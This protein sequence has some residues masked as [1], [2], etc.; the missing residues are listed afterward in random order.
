MLFGVRQADGPTGH[1]HVGGDLSGFAGDAHHGL[2]AGLAFD[3]HVGPG[4]ATGPSGA[5]RLE[6][7]FLGGGCGRVG[8][9][10]SDACCGACSSAHAR[11]AR[12]GKSSR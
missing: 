11:P 12:M 7:G 5:H 10:G 9:L 6:D 1:A 3:A 2:S 8:A 4:N